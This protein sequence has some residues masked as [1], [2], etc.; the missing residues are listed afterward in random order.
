STSVAHIEDPSVGVAPGRYAVLRV[1]DDGCGMS[2]EVKAH[3]FE[4]FFTTK[5]RGQGTGLGLATVYGIVTQ[6]GG[7]VRVESTPGG[8]PTFEGLLPA[9]GAE[10]ESAGD[11]KPS[12]PKRGSET[13]LLV[14]DEAPLRRLIREVLIDSGYSVLEAAN[15]EEALRKCNER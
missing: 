7:H 1:E 2:D 6:G 9:V 4:P 8:G 5:P 15:G 3:L 12:T 11:A 13:V 14:E 10:V